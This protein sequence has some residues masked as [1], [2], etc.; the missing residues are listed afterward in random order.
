MTEMLLL[1]NRQEERESGGENSGELLRAV[2]RGGRMMEKHDE[3]NIRRME[4]LREG[5]ANRESEET[6]REQDAFKWDV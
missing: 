3:L 6:R 5:E 4:C 1:V 2:E